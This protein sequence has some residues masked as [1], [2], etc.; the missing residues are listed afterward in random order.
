MKPHILLVEDDL[1]TG[2]ILQTRLEF[3][4]Y[5]VTQAHNGETAIDMLENDRFE[6]VLTDIVLGAV[7]GIEVLHTA[8]LQSYRPEVII[9]TGYRTLDTSIAAIRAGACDYLLKPCDDE[10]LL[11]CVNEAVERHQEA[12][13][14][15]HTDQQL[16]DAAA[17]IM[18]IC[19][20]LEED[21][22][23]FSGY[24]LNHAVD[25]SEASSLS[26]PSQVLQVGDLLIGDTR[27]KVSFRGAPLRLTPIEYTMLHYL[28]EQPGVV[29][30]CQDI[31]SHTHGFSTSEADAQGLVKPH[32]HNL[33]KKL[34]A[35]Y[36][37]NDRGSG[38][39]LVC[40]QQDS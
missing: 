15:E 36:L 40:P 25:S 37:V 3:A 22:R 33:R 34:G 24:L 4:G 38:Y 28:A 19:G 5:R 30:S 21:Q 10:E 7:D 18:N 27:H 2:R 1:D 29:H 9:L 12:I 26:S 20:T 6:V 35:T 23:F 11:K 32:I 13:Q 14:R 39:K 8:R 31:V 16:K 17:L